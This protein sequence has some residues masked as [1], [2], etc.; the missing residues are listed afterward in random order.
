MY[1]S[2]KEIRSEI[3]K[4]LNINPVVMLSTQ[5]DHG[6][7]FS[8]P[9]YTLAMD[10]DGSL[11]YLTNDPSLKTVE[12]SQHH[13][14]GLSFSDPEEEVYL[15]V[16]GVAEVERD[17][18]IIGQ[19]WEEDFT[20]WFPLGPTDPELALLRVLPHTAEIWNGLE[21]RRLE[22]ATAKSSEVESYEEGQKPGPNREWERRAFDRVPLEPS[23]DR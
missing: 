13:Q 4:C 23:M 12:I 17:S 1:N 21:H 16:S 19:I 18:A 20:Q 11:L 14:V 10:D 15:A 3:E 9:M 2:S 7:I 22:D 8:R 6:K 5:G